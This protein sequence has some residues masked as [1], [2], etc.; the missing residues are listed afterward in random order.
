M[1]ILR[2]RHLGVAVA[3]LALLASVLSLHPASAAT[4]TPAA[5]TG[6]TSTTV[7]VLSWS[8]V[9]SAVK[10]DVQVDDNEDFDSPLFTVQTTN[11]RAV[12]TKRLTGQLYWRVRALDASRNAS[13][14]AESSLELDALD[15]PSQLTPDGEQLSQPDEPPVLSWQGVQGASAYT[16]E[17]DGDPDFI[18]ATSYT[19]TTTSLALPTGL[20]A[21]DYWWRVTASFDA[22]LS[23]PASSA[24]TFTVTPLAAPVQVS[25]A[26]SP[27][28]NVEDVVLDWDPV[29]G[30]ASYELRVSTDAD[31]NNLVDTVTK[32]MGTSYSP[33]LTYDNGAYFWQ[34]RAI[35]TNGRPTEW[36]TVRN[37]FQR[38]WSEQ[39][40]AVYPTGDVGH[41][42]DISGVRYFEWTPIPHAAYYQLVVGSDANFSPGTYTMCRVVGTT[43]TVGNMTS[44]LGHRNDEACTMP[45][46]DVLY[47]R[48]RGIDAPSQSSGVLGLYSK[49][50]AVRWSA[51]SI[52]NAT[53]ANGAT[54]DVPSFSWDP[55]SGVQKYLVVIRNAANDEVVTSAT[56]F[57]TSYT[58]TK[59]GQLD[60]SLTYTW[61][62]QAVGPDNEKAAPRVRTF[63]VSGTLPTSGAGALTPL[64]GNADTPSVRAPQLAWEPQPGAAYYKVWIGPSGTGTFWTATSSSTDVVGDLLPYPRVTDTS[65]RTIKPG[66]YDWYVTA[67]STTGALIGTGPVSTF[68][69][70]DF[71]PVTG[72]S[73]AL[74]G[75]TLA[76]NGGC[77]AH[78]NADGINGPICDGLPTTPVL[79]WD[80]IPGV[81][82]YMVYVAQDPNFTNMLEAT[83]PATTSTWYVPT[84]SNAEATYADSQAGNAYYWFIRPCFTSVLCAPDPE[85]SA[86]HATNAFRKASP[87]VELLSPAADSSPDA[88]NLDDSEVTFSWTDYLETNK[89]TVWA[90]T[91]EQSTQSAR[92]YR[93]QV[94]DSPTFATPLEDVQVDQTTYTSPGRL[95]PDGQLYWRVQV[96]DGDSKAQTW[97]QIR[98]LVK[99][100]PPIEL[101]SP[102]AEDAVSG[103][104]AFRWAPQ[105]FLGAYRIEV[106]RNNDTTFS[107][108]NRVFSETTRATAYTWDEP[109]P[110]SPLPYVWRVRRTDARGNLGSWSA[111]GSFYST[112]ASPALLEPLDASQQ[113]SSGALFTW[114]AVLGATKYR[115]DVKTSTRTLVSAT[116]AN[117]AYATSS[118]LPDGT[119]SWQVTALDPK[120]HVLGVSGTRSFTVD[121]SAPTLVSKSPTGTIR[122]SGNVSVTFSEPVVGVT[123]ATFQILPYGKAK[124]LSAKV[125]MNAAHTRAVLNPTRSLVT[126]RR[127]TLDLSNT[128]TDTSDNRLSTPSWFLIAK[129]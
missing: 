122:R 82:Y 52:P 64:E 39:P 35:D 60:P 3:S 107:L 81:A 79:S 29:P 28:T 51:K 120:S 57:S 108:A 38:S 98:S 4:K 69:V 40:Q 95:Y 24:A 61:S 76:A 110:A 31:F 93:L 111:T 101:L 42:S 44:S 10:Y 116:T 62:V 54:V 123:K 30:A 63:Y 113:P 128:I 126:G 37:S 129:K 56:T 80:P 105:A 11:T 106:Y 78:L 84:M 48:V 125:T 72:Q 14:W 20:E 23:S 45:D 22:T 25:P 92:L 70:G 34:V 104:A 18:S 2:P 9:S 21:G 6:L 46:S 118:A 59:I 15:V 85:S 68:R 73:I 65:D 83:I 12:P 58:P 67:Y 91:G 117:L 19:T 124:P 97:S 94:D 96:I 43:Y 114:S 17:V 115:I 16:V 121:A 5:P 89:A 49:I 71:T 127:Y 74:S 112:G 99:Y 88:P 32:V 109:L 47:W 50:Q 90:E 102:L 66:S 87:A 36:R 13:D 7:P 86:G 77:T 33:A 41:P 8:A 75:Q 119:T 55:V 53:P 1:R 100:S 26:D 27:D 103:T